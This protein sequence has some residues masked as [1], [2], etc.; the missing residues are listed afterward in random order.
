MTLKECYRILGVETSTSLED[1]KHAYRRRAFELHPDLNPHLS[2]A[3]N[4]FQLLN[5]AYVI[6]SRLAAVREA[7]E[8]RLRTES[9]GQGSA[10]NP[11][12]EAKA[13]ENKHAATAASGSAKAESEDG[14]AQK[15]SGAAE[16]KRPDAEQ[17]E[18]G[19]REAP[20]HAGGDGASAPPGPEQASS[21]D[22]GTSRPNKENLYTEQQ[23]VLR[24]ILNDPFARRVFEDIYSEIR[25]KGKPGP[26]TASKPTSPKS[27]PPRP[28]KGIGELLHHNWG[29]SKSTVDFSQGMGGAVKNWL[30]SQIDEEQT[31]HLPAARLF[32]GARIRLQIRRGLSES[33]TTVEVTLPP[34][35]TA[36]KPI[37]L[38]GMGKKVGRWQG[39]LYLRLMAGN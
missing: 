28:S 23:E 30:R 12:Q 5:E 39:D 9:E 16:S 37:R 19:A 14:G 11:Q 22:Q 34:D 32:P 7:R 26:K 21:R 24:D 20:P 8:E 13:A 31:F 35:F 2:D 4:Q 15:T 17:K 27:T 3:G 33:L 10:S 29:R 1:I 6:L 36:G 25:K 38:K 18:T